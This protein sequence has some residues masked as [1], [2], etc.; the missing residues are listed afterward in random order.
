M[1]NLTPTEKLNK[2]NAM[3]AIEPNQPIYYNVRGNVYRELMQL[4]D[5]VKEY[6]HALT[7]NEAYAE[8]HVNL[9]IALTALEKETEAIIHLKKAIAINPEITTALNQLADIYLRQGHFNEARDLLLASLKKNTDDIPVC[10][11]LG[12]A[13]YKLQDLEQA[14]FY[15][16]N[17]L[18][19]NHKY[20]EINQYLGNTY[21][22]IQDHEKALYYYYRQLEYNPFF[23]TYYNIGVLLMMKERLKE[24][25][26]YF[27]QAEKISPDNIDVHLNLGNVFLKQNKPREAIFHYEKVNTLNPHDP[28]IQHILSALKQE[29]TPHSAPPKYVSNLFDQYAPYYDFHLTEALK[30]N[31]PEQLFHAVELDYPLLSDTKIH[32]I[33][34]GCGTGLCGKFFKP[35]SETLT[36]IDLSEKMLSV[37]REKNGYDELIHEDIA[38]A[39]LRFKTS[40]LIYAADVFTYLGD[41]SITFQNSYNALKK[42]GLFAFTVEKTHSNDF[43]LQTSIR[44]AHSKIYLEKLITQTG[45]SVVRFDNIVLRK[46]RNEPIEGYLILLRK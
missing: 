4:D 45:F 16:E 39:L 17:V 44:Y 42:E 33:D 14:R 21:L 15:F 32:I 38:S 34:L 1:Q 2:I 35:F 18:M 13:Y 31:T 28:E 40:D 6:Q 11:R 20:E 5:A 23:E 8:A 26:V 19:F 10:Y 12:I 46:Q 22:E 37:A 43:I 29:Q 3:I 41:L 30:Y 7:L 25:L 27:Y 9:G 36:G 24:S